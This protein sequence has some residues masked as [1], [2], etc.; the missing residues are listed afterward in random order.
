VKE[1]LK[2]GKFWAGIVVGVLL[3][4]FFPQF[5]PRAV[6]SSKKSG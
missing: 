4:A 1:T 6:L 5:N 3:L 2:S